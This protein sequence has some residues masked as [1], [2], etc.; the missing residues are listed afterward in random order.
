MPR[1]A[2]FTVLTVLV[3]SFSASGVR[4]AD[5]PMASGHEMKFLHGLHERGYHDLA[6]EYIDKLR[7]S[8]DTP[9]DLK[10]RLDYE[11]GRGMLEEASSMTDLERKLVVL[12]NARTR[13][14]AFAHANAK[15]P[16]AAQALTSMARILVER[17]H[18]AVLQASELKG[19]EAQ[20]KLAEAR[21]ALSSAREAYSNAEKQLK[22]VVDSFPKF[23][24]DGDSRKQT[25][26]Q[27]RVAYT[28]CL[29]ERAL[30]DYEDAQTYALDPSTKNRRLDE[31]RVAFNQIYKDYRLMLAGIYARMWEAKCMEEKGDLGPA[32]GIY[33]ELMEH[34]AVELRDLQRQVQFYQIIIDGK[35]GDYALAVD[36][37]AAWLNNNA[38]KRRSVEG[39]GVQLQLAKNILAQLPQI[40]PAG[41]DEAIRKATDRL[42][43]VVRVYSPY[44][45]EAVELLS[46]F[47]RKSTHTAAQ[48][49]AMS[50][51]D[52][53]EE[54]NQMIN[55]QEW[56]RAVVYYKHAVKKADPNK[57]IDKANRARYFI[58]YCF[59]RNNRF[60]EAAVVAEH[61][62]YHYPKGGLTPQATEF[63]I[64]AWVMA[65]NE[66]TQIDRRTDLKR[67]VEL[68]KYT[69][70]TWPD[71]DQAD[72]ARHTLGVIAMGEGH[73]LESAK[74]FESI[75]ES[76][77]KRNDGLVAASDAHWRLRRD[78]SEA[79]KT[80]EA[81][82]EGK[83]AE[84]LADKALKARQAAGLSS[85]DPAYITNAVALAEIYRATGRPKEAITLLNPM[86]QAIV[87]GPKSADTAAQ[88]SKVLTTLL[89]SHIAN[90]DANLAVSDMKSL[91]SV[92]TDQESLTVL[93][94]ELARSLKKEM[95][96]LEAKGR[97]AE[98][99]K[100]T[101]AYQ[102]FLDALANSKSGQNYDM[103]EWAGESML[104]LGRAKEA[105][106]VLDR[107]LETSTKD[108]SFIGSP[109]KA[110]DKIFRTRLRKAE[111]LRKSHQFQDA[112][113]LVEEMRIERPKMIEIL[114]ERGYLLEDWAQADQTKWDGSLTYWKWLGGR[115]ESVRPRPVQYYE[116][117]QHVALALYKKGD[118]L[119]ATQTLKG[120][121]TLSPT[122]G[123]PEMKAKYQ[124]LLKQMGS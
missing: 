109:V 86:S 108:P 83:K 54:G 37:S 98:L 41:R 36:R 5:D 61:L 102:Q 33:K 43:E 1:C 117:W 114:M 93:F 105:I 24:P 122:V 68:A 97:T 16:L 53:M 104:S 73:Y 111:A 81:D 40:E 59:L 26:E 30:V 12:D 95:D 28:N 45:A 82:A 118:K 75:R 92:S 15:H 7:K 63:G 124:A 70:Q 71:S 76:S 123:S 27:A 110:A 60:Y 115:F 84:E 35:R 4:A 39:L 29:L 44:K 47:K 67:L 34:T 79:G 80:T 2:F 65:Y 56:D 85:T 13:L 31:A 22:T 19:A 49:A 91:E 94:F 9:A 90:G 77:P 55:T 101:Q 107:V 6:L 14:A 48:I 38:N 52:A 113:K 89:R 32:M 121:M 25:S 58:A 87:N 10:A 57:E 74:E 120:V 3:A 100:T 103:L 99:Q 20:T 18:T 21:S 72:T 66:F 17:G 50:F 119:K 88:N 69:A 23:I 11:E 62:A 106:V 51:D 116:C 8:P 42:S 46:K 78:L 96:D 112:E 64:N